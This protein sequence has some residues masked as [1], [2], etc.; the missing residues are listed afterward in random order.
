MARRAFRVVRAR[1]SIG[2]KHRADGCAIASAQGTFIVRVGIDGYGSALSVVSAAFFGG[3][4][5]HAGSIANVAA[6]EAVDAIVRQAFRR[7]C[8]SETVV[9]LARARARATPAI[10]LV[11]GIGIV[12]DGAAGSVRPAA[13]FRRRTR[14]APS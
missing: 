10:T 2:G 7:L 9:E 6:T 12:F 8:A 14:F 13:F 4:T 1:R 11:V 3:R 5:S